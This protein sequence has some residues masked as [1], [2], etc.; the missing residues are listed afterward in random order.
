MAAGSLPAA[1]EALYDRPLRVMLVP[2][3]GGTEEGT[4]ADFEPLFD[5]LTNM[6]GLT[7]EIRVGQSYASVIEAIA[8]GLTDLAYMGTVSFLTAS[9]RGPVE[10]LAISE[11]NGNFFYYSGLFTR[12]DSGIRTL[13]DIPGRTIVFSDPRSSSGFVYPLAHLLKNEI[14]PVRD[15]RRIILSGSHSNSLTALAEGRAE[16][17]AAPFESYLKSV[18][19]GAIDPRDIHI[20]AKSDPIPNPPIAANSELPKA[21][22][23]ALREALHTVHRQPGINPNMIR[24]H[25][26]NIVDRYNAEVS[27]DLFVLARQNMA[28]IDDDYRGAVLRKAGRRN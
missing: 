4:R 23:D 16:V 2:S 15:A 6:T 24:G 7:F 19:Q 27:P 5:A 17:A 20:I 14:D 9:D 11:E 8:A 18:R 26:G 25:A 10:L 3:D 21:V 13:A 12:E 22:L 1:G 28:L